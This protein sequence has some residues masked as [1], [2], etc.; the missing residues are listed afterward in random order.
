MNWAFRM[1]N[2]RRAA[3]TDATVWRV[4]NP[5]ARKEPSTTADE[6]AML[7]GWLDYH[8]ATLLTKCAGLADEQLRRRSVEPS[9]LS[10]I[11]LLRHLTICE[12]G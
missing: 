8:R 2:R 10:L 9:A 4:I 5:P 7:D 11:G 3:A 12:Y 1:K 6:R